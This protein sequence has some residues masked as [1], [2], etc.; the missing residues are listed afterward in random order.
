[1]KK[2]RV[3]RHS[4]LQLNPEYFVFPF[5]FQ[6]HQ[7]KIHRDILHAVLHGFGTWSVTLRENHR[8][9]MF[10]DRNVRKIS[11]PKRNEVN[12]GYR[13]FDCEE[14]HKLY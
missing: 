5:S 6:K 12:G 13:N 3:D 11:G 1:M 4:L 7:I 8:L 10:D 14:L 2:L 9:W